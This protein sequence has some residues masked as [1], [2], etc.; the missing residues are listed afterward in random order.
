VEYALLYTFSTI[1]QTIAA[2]LGV[3]AAFVLYRLQSG[4][5]TQWDDAQQLLNDF[6]AHTKTDSMPETTLGQL[7]GA[8]D[9]PRLAMEFEVRFN[10]PG[11]PYRGLTKEL[12]LARLKASVAARDRIVTALTRAFWVTASVILASVVILALAHT[13]W[14]HPVTSWTVLLLGFVMLFFCLRLYWLVICAAL[15]IDYRYRGQ[16]LDI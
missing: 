6:G 14:T 3:L 4:S 8:Q 15:G 9:Y 2:A 12:A 5:T 11:V 1:P 10:D 13:I 16:V 7:L